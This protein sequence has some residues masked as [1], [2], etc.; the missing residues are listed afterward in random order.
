MPWT[1]L[2]LRESAKKKKEKKDIILPLLG[3]T[4][5]EQNTQVNKTYNLL[6][7]DKGNL[8]EKKKKNRDGMRVKGRSRRVSYFL[9]KDGHRS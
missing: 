4:D 6:E 8:E 9:K 3:G 2:G 5:N 1:V 7:G